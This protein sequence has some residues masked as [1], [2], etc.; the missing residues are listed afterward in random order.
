MLNIDKSK[1]L[2]GLDIGSNSIKAVELK[3]R[4]KGGEEFFELVKAGYEVLPQDAIVEGTIIDTTAVTETIKMIFD[5][6]KIANKNVTISIS[7]NAVIIKKIS[8][9]QMEQ[10]ELAESIQKAVHLPICPH[11]SGDSRNGAGHAGGLVHV[12]RLR[13]IGIIIF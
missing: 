8:L 1:P 6:T 3:S 2:V 4:K 13:I 11:G 12:A 5:E 10:E 7:G 9:P